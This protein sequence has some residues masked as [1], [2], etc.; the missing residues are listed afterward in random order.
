MV[1]AAAE[2]PAT[3]R[4]GASEPLISYAALAF[5]LAVAAYL[6]FRG[7]GDDSLWRDE[8][9]SWKQATAGGL[10]DVIAATAGDNYPP[11][12]N[13][14]LWVSIAALGDGEWALR[15]PSAICGILNVAAI[16]WVGTL[17]AGRVAGLL[18]ALLLA[19]SGFHI[20]FSQEARMYSLLA[21][22]ATLFAGAAFRYSRRPTA[23]WAIAMVLAGIALL[24][25]H[26]YGALTW[27]SIA[28]ALSA[29]IFWKP[30]SGMSLKQWLV[31]QAIIVA[32]FLPWVWV[33]LSRAAHIVD[34]GFWIAYPTPDFVA[35]HIDRLV[36]GPVMLF[37]LGLGMAAAFVREAESPSGGNAPSTAR[38]KLAASPVELVLLAWAIGPLVLGYLASVMTTPVLYSRYLIGSLPAVLLLASIGL[39]RFAAGRITTLAVFAV[40]AGAAWIGMT[41]DSPGAR[42]DWRGVGE[43]LAETF[44]PSNCLLTIDHG[45]TTAISYYYRQ[46]IDCVFYAATP[47]QVEPGRIPSDLVFAVLYRT[48]AENDRVVRAFT[49]PPWRVGGQV[50][51][52]RI[53]VVAIVR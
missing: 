1:E 13:L 53:D 3:R 4:W 22:A 7:L 12:H 50:L 28:L 26:P 17:V 36:T 39:T 31:L 43:L 25:S 51:L 18:S 16:Y 27:L 47:D 2:A 20:W 33:L 15:L 24:Y 14:V 38:L 5:I 41:R 8:A 9:A 45:G 19:L 49:E 32:A 46:P 44:R 42:E 21:L 10:A 29:V 23:P 52:Y 6:R 34:G 11:L 35:E 30:P 40:A 48:R 37:V